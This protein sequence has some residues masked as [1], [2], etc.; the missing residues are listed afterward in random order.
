MR[1]QNK[2]ERKALF[3]SDAEHQAALADFLFQ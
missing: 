1:V 2:V 3:F